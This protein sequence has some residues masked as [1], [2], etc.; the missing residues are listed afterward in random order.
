MDGATDA[1]L[2]GLSAEGSELAFSTFYDRHSHAV[3][4]Y[5]IRTSVQPSDA[6]ELLQLTFIT[7]WQK[8]AAVRIAEDS[9]LPW[10]LVTCRNHALNLERSRRR[11]R[12]VSLHEL[13]ELPA[14]SAE[15]DT[16]LRD[17]LDELDRLSESDR[18]LCRLCLIEGYT[19]KEA[20]EH[21]GVSVGAVAKRLERA[22]IRLRKALLHG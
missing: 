5:A 9:A 3:L 12:T 19:Y 16:D 15:A 14:A 10:L 7:A 17:L 4:R 2:L 21:L 8:A 11:R 6:Q 1:E 20:A 22:R 18:E 13:A